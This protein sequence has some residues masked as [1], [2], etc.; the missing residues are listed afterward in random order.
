MRN[1]GI[2]ELIPTQEYVRD[3][4]SVQKWMKRFRRQ[5]DNKTSNVHLVEFEDGNVYIHDGHTRLISSLLFLGNRRFD[6]FRDPRFG[7]L[8]CIK[9]PET[10]IYVKFSKM[11]YSDYT[12]AYPS[13]GFYTP[14]DPRTEVRKTDFFHVKE[15][16]KPRLDED[17][18][19]NQHLIDECAHLYK[20][21]REIKDL[22]ELANKY[23]FLKEIND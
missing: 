20:R 13:K 10:N 17:F 18:E 1:I 12:H 4:S 16:L 11:K 8:P 22:Q 3:I 19:R 7:D 2:A 6:V 23:A 9:I 5:E 21:K 14:F 15:F